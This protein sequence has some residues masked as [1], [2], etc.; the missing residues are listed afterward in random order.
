MEYRLGAPCSDAL[1]AAL[2]SDDKTRT[3]LQQP[4]A[5]GKE[6]QHE[7]LCRTGRCAVK[8]REVIMK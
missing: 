1:D 5:L 3:V 4:Q 8:A 7:V 2:R 6:A